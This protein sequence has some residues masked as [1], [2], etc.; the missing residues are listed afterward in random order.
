ATT[1][2]NRTILFSKWLGSILNDRWSWLWLG[3]IGIV[4]VALGALH[5]WAIPCFVLAWLVYAALLAGLAMWFSVASRNSRR[6]LIGTLVSC[7][8]G[9]VFYILGAYD[10]AEG[11]LT[12][13]EAYSL[14]PPETLGLLAFSP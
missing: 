8:V 11:W 3:L 9:S 13:S 4:G 14:L 5:P 10:L 7:L 6:A 2:R 1:L 12:S